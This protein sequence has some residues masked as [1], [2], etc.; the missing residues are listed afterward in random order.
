MKQEIHHITQ[1]FSQLIKKYEKSNCTNCS[2][3]QNYFKSEYKRLKLKLQS[4]EKLCLSNQFEINILSETQRAA[5]VLGLYLM[6]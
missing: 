2:V 3:L 4:V 1:L 6:V 5:G